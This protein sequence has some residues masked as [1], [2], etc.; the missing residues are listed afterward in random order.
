MK[1]SE[2][3]TKIQFV[4]W[5][6]FC[7]NKTEADMKIFGLPGTSFSPSRALGVDVLNRSIAKKTGIPMTK[8]GLERK[9]GRTI[10]KNVKKLVK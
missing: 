10:I 6:Y 5:A 8:S 2:T 7:I 4:K 1:N 9:V 3:I